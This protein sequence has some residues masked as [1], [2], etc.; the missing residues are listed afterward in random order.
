MV[1]NTLC[2]NLSIISLLL[3]FVLYMNYRTNE[4]GE[5][6]YFTRKK[7]KKIN[8][9]IYDISHK[10]LPNLHEYENN[11]INII[12]LGIALPLIMN[13]KIFIEFIT[14]FII[15]LIIRSILIYVTILPGHSKCQNSN[16]SITSLGGCYDK[17]ISGHT[18]W[19]FLAS[20]FLHKYKILSIHSLIMINLLN[21]MFLL[22][23]RAHYTVDILLGYLLTGL[24][25][26]NNINIKI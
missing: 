10:Y 4:I 5:E 21:S 16:Y 1:S 15:I 8:P 23:T 2:L 14:L 25:F 22:S 19:V 12:P 26:Q 24:I 18:A 17:I 3:I 20:L 7:Q 13:L 11:I 6:F 9:K